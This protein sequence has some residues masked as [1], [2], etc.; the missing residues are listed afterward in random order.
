M[1][2]THLKTSSKEKQTNKSALKTI[3]ITCYLLNYYYHLIFVQHWD[4]LQDE[5]YSLLFDYFDINFDELTLLHKMTWV[6]I[7]S[8][9]KTTKKCSIDLNIDVLA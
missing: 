6:N 9:N 2:D 8:R 3:H 1:E 4:L 5:Y 7:K